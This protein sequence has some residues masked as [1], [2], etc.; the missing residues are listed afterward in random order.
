M[1]FCD[2]TFSIT[3][4]CALTGAL[5]VAVCTARPAV[6][7]RVPC[8]VA[9]VGAAASQANTH[10]LLGNRAL[11]LLEQGQS[12]AEALQ[13]VLADDEGRESR[14]VAVMSA[15]G[16]VAVFTGQTVLERNV[17]AG[18]LTGPDCV[19]AGNLLT[20]G[21]TLE[22]MVAAFTSCRGFLGNRLLA[23]LEAGQ[24]AGGDKRGK[25]SAALRV[26]LHPAAMGAQPL[27]PLDVRVDVSDNPVQDL[28]AVYAAYLQAFE[29]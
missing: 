26:S 21:E 29:G 25:V 24:K 19:A 16:Q 2:N 3:A 18:S 13:A 4:R 17:W 28:H 11:A 7:N 15:H 1:V 8:V 12:P 6:G 27:W 5:G 10:P 9:G 22:A 20:G 23:A 14:Q